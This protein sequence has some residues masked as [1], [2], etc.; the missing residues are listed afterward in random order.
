MKKR[1]LL[2]DDEPRYR[3]LYAQALS[4]L[5]VEIAHAGTAEEALEAMASGRVP[6]LVVSDVRMPGASGIELLERA[7]AEHTGLPFLLVTAHADVREA[8]SALK[9]GAVDYLAKPVNLDELLACVRDGLGEWEQG[10]LEDPPPELL[11][12][13][14]AVSPSMRALLREA[15]CVARGEVNVLLMGESGTGKEVLSRFIHRASARSGGP[16]V[17]VNCAALPASLL[18]SELFGHV[19]GAFTG[20][21][22]SR[23]GRFQEADG[24]TLFLDEIGDMPLEL[25]PVFL[26]ALERRA[27][28]PV[29]G[30]GERK[31]DFRLVAATNRSL[32]EDIQKGL[33]RADLFYRLNVVALEL[34]PLRERR[35][36]ILPMARHFL[37]KAGG[38]GKRIARAAGAL[39]EGYDWPGNIRELENAMER[40]HL[41][42]R[43]EVILPENL[44]AVVRRATPF[45]GGGAVAEASDGPVRTLRETEIES[46]KRA[47]EQTGGNRTHAARLLGITRRGLL[48]KLKRFDL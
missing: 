31:V 2:V 43:T 9:L 4:G 29:G 28:T 25:Q 18:N 34:P 47:L 10:N 32:E 44:P 26:R 5:G 16:M 14:V 6:D 8:V 41:L 30:T 38:E 22:A 11:D 12:G 21:V 20:A 23:K 7:R 46:L 37:A 15:W 36:D 17:A 48:K 24:G 27:I 40:A 39:L 45:E 35:E 13:L 3:E 33:F 1:V 42:T 19:K